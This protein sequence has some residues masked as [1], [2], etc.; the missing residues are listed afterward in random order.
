MAISLCKIID[1]IWNVEERN[2]NKERYSTAPF[3]PRF[4]NTNQAKRCWVNYIDYWKCVKAKG[5]ADPVCDQFKFVYTEICPMIWLEKWQT[6]R[7]EGRF[8]VRDINIGEP[9][10]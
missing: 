5:E 1:L 3:D 7:E 10:F 6:L 2:E 8:Q 9:K 4:P